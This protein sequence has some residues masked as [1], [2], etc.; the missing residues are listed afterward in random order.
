MRS[1][2]SCERTN[3]AIGLILSLNVRPPFGRSGPWYP[4]LAN[5][6]D[7][8]IG[9]LLSAFFQSRQGTAVQVTTKTHGE[10]FIIAKETERSGLQF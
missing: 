6:I 10:T 7:P 8:S 9:I 3:P 2:C 5:P 1:M 4:G